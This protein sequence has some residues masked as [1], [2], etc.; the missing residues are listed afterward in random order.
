MPYPHWLLSV[1]QSHA[2]RVAIASAEIVGDGSCSS[3]LIPSDARRVDI[4]PLTMSGAK[5]IPIA[6]R[7]SLATRG[8]V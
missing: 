3:A 6:G 5:A 7:T 4:L 2:R 1:V 8:A